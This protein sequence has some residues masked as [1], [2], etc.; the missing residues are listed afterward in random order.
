MSITLTQICQAIETTLAPAI[1]YTQTASELKDGMNDQPIL[2]VYPNSGT[3]LAGT[4]QNDRTTFRADL[5]QAE[6]V[7]YAD[8]YATPR[9]EIGED[10]AVL[11]PLIDAVINEIEKQDTKPY[12]GLVGIKG[13]YW[14]WQQVILI[15]NDPAQPFLGARFTFTLRVY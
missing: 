6:I 11:L 3:S 9:S 2:Q 12:F 10:F 4:Q 5:R 14:G 13:F 8:L 1:T 15:Y 7:I